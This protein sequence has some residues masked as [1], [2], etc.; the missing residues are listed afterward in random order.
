MQEE[1]ATYGLPGWF[2]TTIGALKI[3]LAVCLLI[4]IWVPTITT[5]AAIGMALLM[6]GAVSMHVK[7][8][9]PLK[10]SL[11][12]ASMLLLSLIVAAG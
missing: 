7:V 2:M 10:K 11:P 9:D 8:G 1:F 5:P 6:L 3:T 12:A 4:G